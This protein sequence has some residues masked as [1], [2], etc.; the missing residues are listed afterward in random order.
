MVA[1][2]LNCQQRFVLTKHSNAYLAVQ[3]FSGTIVY[4]TMTFKNTAG[5]HPYMNSIGHKVEYTTSYNLYCI[6]LYDY[7]KHNKK[8]K[9]IIIHDYHAII[10]NNIIPVNSKRCAKSVLSEYQLD[11]SP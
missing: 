5:I 8:I 4:Y 6:V 11:T 7:V 2:E 3:P 1:R 10:I 9:Y